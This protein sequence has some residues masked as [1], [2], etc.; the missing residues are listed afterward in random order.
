MSPRERYREIADDLRRR[1]HEGEWQPGE[2]IPRM[3][4]LGRHYGAARGSV[5]QAIHRL[6]ADGLLSSTPR[7]G[8]VV[9]DPEAKPTAGSGD[10]EETSAAIDRH[11]DVIRGDLAELKAG[12][13]EIRDLLARVV[14]RLEGVQP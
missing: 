4:D 1:I 10:I 13:V 14:A 7:R 6:E 12:R 9:C 11:L 5:A 8:T 2:T 3:V